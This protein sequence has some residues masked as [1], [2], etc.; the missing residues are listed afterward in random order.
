MTSATT[1]TLSPPAPNSATETVV[2]IADAVDPAGIQ[3]LEAAGCRVVSMPDLGPDTLPDAVRE[4]NPHALVVR[5]TKVPAP[6]FEHAARL[7]LIVR[8]GAGYDNIDV[9]AAS[10]SGVFVANCPGKNALAVAELAWGLIL[11]CDRAIPDQVAET[12]AGVWN[13][14][15][16]AKGPRGMAGRTL[17]I[18]GLGRI[19][20]AIAE[21]GR[22]FEMDVVI[23]S[24]S[25]TPERAEAM[26][27][28]YAATPRDVARQSDVISV[29]VASTPETRHLIDADLIAAMPDHTILVNTA[30]GEVIDEAALQAALESRPLR[31]GL[32]VWESQPS[33]KDSDL[34]N[35]IAKLGNVYGTHH[36]GASTEQS[37]QAIADETVRVVQTWASTGEILNCVNRLAA[38]RAACMLTVRHLNQPG[39]LAHVFRVL[40]EAQVNVEEMENI[41]LEGEKAALA[42]I[43]LS[44]M[45]ADELIHAVRGGPHVIAADAK[46]V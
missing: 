6:V 2:L 3:A 34:P 37:Q 4:H 5:S 31:A 43:Q 16:W 11:S 39:V 10:A 27:F 35:T 20:R 25:M 42:R 13:K 14:K 46:P 29:C 17:G 12:S 41:M 32:D 23:W 22:A 7:G 28:R 44:V 21:R 24:R 36:N 45:P 8:A 18:I 9:A 15:K 40:S 19:G 38:S 30:R 33:P 1:E 26:G